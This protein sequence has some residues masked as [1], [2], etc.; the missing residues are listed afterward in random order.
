MQ[1]PHAV[2]VSLRQTDGPPPGTESRPL[3]VPDDGLYELLDGKLMEKNVGS[4]QIE[5]AFGWL[6]PSLLLRNPVAWDAR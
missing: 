1:S 3:T 6:T 5:I 4:Q 2:A